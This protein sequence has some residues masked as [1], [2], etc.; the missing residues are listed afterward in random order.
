LHYAR[1]FDHIT[2][3]RVLIARHRSEGDDRSLHE[4]RRLLERL[5]EA[6]EKGGRTG[7]VIEILVLQAVAQQALVK[8]QGR[9]AQ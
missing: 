8:C 5:L 3:A 4:V 7:A 2:L 6:A 1:E 9:I